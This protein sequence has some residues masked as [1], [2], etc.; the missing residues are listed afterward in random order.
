MKYLIKHLSDT[1]KPL[2]NAGGPL[3]DIGCL[4]WAYTGGP[5]IDTHRR[6][7]GKA[8][9]PQLSPMK[10]GAVPHG[11]KVWGQLPPLPPRFLRPWVLQSGGLDLG[12]EA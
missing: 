12:Q 10:V 8:G 7:P 6:P 11:F 3:A 4:Y 1:R 5:L 2:T 9:L